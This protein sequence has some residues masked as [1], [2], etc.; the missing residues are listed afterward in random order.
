[1]L[2]KLQIRLEKILVLKIKEPFLK[3]ISEIINPKKADAI[4]RNNLPSQ[5][6]FTS[7]DYTEMCWHTP[8]ARLYIGRPM[9]TR[10]RC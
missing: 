8:T 5:L 10:A 3:E 7:D 2:T 4:V 6:N 9:L 1:M